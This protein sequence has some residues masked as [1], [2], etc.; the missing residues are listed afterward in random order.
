MT[1]E[2]TQTIKI[3]AATR[4]RIKLLAVRNNETMMQLIDRL[5]RQEEEEQ[6]MN[7]APLFASQCITHI[8][9]LLVCRGAACRRRSLR[10]NRQVGQVVLVLARVRGRTASHHSPVATPDQ[11]TR[12]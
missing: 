10:P 2:P 5:V 6:T 7:C 12:G 1:A 3:H 8:T 11:S 4:H 9:I